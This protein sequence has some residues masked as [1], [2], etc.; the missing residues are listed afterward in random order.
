MYPFLKRVLKHTLN[1]IF[2]DD[3][4]EGR[5]QA[6]T[7]TK[8]GSNYHPSTVECDFSPSDNSHES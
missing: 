6:Q 5:Q 3:S 4:Y 1:G 2:V 8:D 7:Q